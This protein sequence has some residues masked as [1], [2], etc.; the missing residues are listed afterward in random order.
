MMK[1]LLGIMLALLLGLCIS[2][3]L[4]PPT[5]VFS[6]VIFIRSN[7]GSAERA[8][9]TKDERSKWWPQ[10]TGNSELKPVYAF[11]SY[12]YEFPAYTYSGSTI[13]I[14][15]NDQRLNSNIHFIQMQNDSVAIKWKAELPTTKNPFRKISNYFKALAMK[16][17]MAS[18]LE[19]VKAFL[20]EEKNL[21]GIK[22]IE[23]KVKD[24]ILISTK[25][26]SASRPT[27]T[28]IYQRITG[29]KK[30]IEVQ[31]ALETNHPMLNIFEDRDSF[32]NMVAI[33]VNK[34]LQETDHFVV[35]KM[36]PGNI[37]TTE[38]KGGP[39]ASSAAVKQIELYI[40]DHKR[41]SPAIPF[42]SLV[43]NRMEEKDSAKWV[44]KVYYPVY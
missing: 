20:S 41:T 19:S 2:Y 33:P 14:Y 25:W 32:I 8:F 15:G 34:I 29:L 42:E 36:I 27:T 31:K 6:K 17:N 35:K 38:V 12:Q 5:I 9:Q 43:T 26:T 21:Y 11:G 24:T 13:R 23:E 30:Y 7:A 10:D 16:K 3:L 22:I 44:T 18:I 4:I 1:V 37:L 40:E 39:F 28:E